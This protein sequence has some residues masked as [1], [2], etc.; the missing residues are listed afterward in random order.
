MKI[1][2]WKKYLMCQLFL[3][4]SSFICIYWTAQIAIAEQP[5]GDAA[6]LI[7]QQGEQLCRK[8]SFIDGLA[9]LQSSLALTS[10]AEQEVRLKAWE[11]QAEQR[12]ISAK[13]F[14]DQAVSIQ[15]KD[16]YGARRLFMKS[17][18]LW[19]DPLLASHIA[20]LKSWEV[21]RLNHLYIADAHP[22]DLLA[23][24]D[25]TVPTDFSLS[26]RPGVGKSEQRSWTI[27]TLLPDRRLQ[28][29][30]YTLSNSR[31]RGHAAQ[32]TSISEMQVAPE[33]L[34]IFWNAIAACGF[35]DMQQSYVQPGFDRKYSIPSH[36]TIHCQR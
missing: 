6:S 18:K 35:A 34:I 21:K 33:K 26:F 5:V 1:L 23:L 9:M 11:E 25:R 32:T 15:E 31:P 30:T 17:W 3:A 14:W 28:E 29:V 7:W 27:S 13:K 24:T 12:R 19:P 36:L 4:L 22:C 2:F 10:S 8:G 16:P 20:E